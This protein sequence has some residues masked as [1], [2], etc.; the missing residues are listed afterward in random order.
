MRRRALQAVQVNIDQLLDTLINTIA[1]GDWSWH[2]RRTVR[3]RVGRLNTT[4][5]AAENRLE[6]AASVHLPGDLE[7]AGL[8]LRLFDLEL[9]A[10]R[11]AAIVRRS[12]V[13]T[14]RP[15]LGSLRR[16]RTAGSEAA[17]DAA[18][19]TLCA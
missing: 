18:A 7:R 9:A 10:E 8:M 16:L 2:G 6:R 3:A 13:Q 17:V 11:V 14:L 12:G 19:G 1:R 4:I 15:Q 5:L